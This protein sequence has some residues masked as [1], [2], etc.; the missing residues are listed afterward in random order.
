VDATVSVIAQRSPRNE[1]VHYPLTPE[2]TSRR[3]VLT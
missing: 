1:A 2:N 3:W